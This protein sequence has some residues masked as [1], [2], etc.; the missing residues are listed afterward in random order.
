MVAFSNPEGV[1]CGRVTSIVRNLMYNWTAWVTTSTCACLI[2]RHAM[3]ILP[4]ACS[5][6][7]A[8]AR[9]VFRFGSDWPVIPGRVADRYCEIG[10]KTSCRRDCAPAFVLAGA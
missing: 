8:Y 4:M 1:I 7:C 10:P 9:A 5:F 6:A 2:E 3:P